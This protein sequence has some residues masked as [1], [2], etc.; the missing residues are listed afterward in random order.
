MNTQQQRPR[1]QLF[2]SYVPEFSVYQLRARVQ[3]L[4]A[5]CQSSVFTSYV[6]EFSVYQLRARVQCLP[7]TCQSSAVYQLRAC[8]DVYLTSYA[9]ETLGLHHVVWIPC[10]HPVLSPLNVLKLPL[11]VK[12]P[13]WKH[14][15]EDKVFDAFDNFHFHPK[16]L[17]PNP[18]GY[19]DDSTQ[20]RG[21]ANI[22]E[23]LANE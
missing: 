22:D 20:K 9:L 11:P 2:T 3:C 23:N 6:P 19:F 17:T 12:H 18:A 4:R 1:V 8:L 14:L 21:D 10:S 15:N 5:T 7:A 13:P 16:L